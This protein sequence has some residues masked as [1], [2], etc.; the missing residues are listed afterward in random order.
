M[1]FKVSIL[2][3]SYRVVEILSY[4]YGLIKKHGE[5]YIF[6]FPTLK[7]SLNILLNKAP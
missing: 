5:F 6:S 3:N 4:Y 2:Q 1:K 7:K